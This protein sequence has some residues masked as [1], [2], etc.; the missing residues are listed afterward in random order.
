MVHVNPILP[1]ITATV[2]GL[3]IPIKSQRQ[4]ECIKIHDPTIHDL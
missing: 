3:N 2:N 4:T 1:L